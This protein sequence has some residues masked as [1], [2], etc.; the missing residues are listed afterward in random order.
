MFK[1]ASKGFTLIELMIV[2]AIVGILAA[3]AVPAY[4]DYAI[5]SKTTEALVAAS[6]VRT[7]LSEGYTQNRV[8]GLDAAATAFNLSSITEK[9][10]KYVANI[11]V[12]VVGAVGAPCAP[13]LSDG[14]W[15]IFVTIAANASNGIPLGLNGMTFTLSPN[16]NNAAP[17]AASN[18]SIDWACASSTSITAT[19]RGM[20]NIASGT[21]PAKYLP[22]ECR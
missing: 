16:V 10:S 21:M 5:R 3:I 17:T 9:R 8:V 4:Q 7:F 15:P 2:L 22:A 1:I 6:I 18:E 12:G 14:A 19:A 13:Y 20:T 11:C